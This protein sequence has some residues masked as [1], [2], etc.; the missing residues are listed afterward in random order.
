MTPIT[1]IYYFLTVELFKD[2]TFMTLVCD[3]KQDSV[4][5]AQLSGAFPGA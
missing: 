5:K 2:I 1:V 4:I 3:I